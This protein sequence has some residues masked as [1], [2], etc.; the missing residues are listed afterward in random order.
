MSIVFFPVT[1]VSAVVLAVELAMY[2][3]AVGSSDRA[4]T[5]DFCWAVSS[6]LS[7]TWY[8]VI[9]FGLTDNGVTVVTEVTSTGVAGAWTALWALYVLGTNHRTGDW[10]I[11]NTEL[12]SLL[13]EHTRVPWTP[14][15]SVVFAWLFIIVY[16]G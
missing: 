1:I 8:M 11:D 4:M 9:L 6:L 3:D 5:S 2:F 15:T 7:F 10:L 12:G 13:S 16:T 14:V